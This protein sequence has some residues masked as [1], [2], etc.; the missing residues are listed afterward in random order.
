MLSGIGEPST[1]AHRGSR[2]RLCPPLQRCTSFRL[3]R[4]QLQGS[5][6]APPSWPHNDLSTDC[7]SLKLG[8]PPWKAVWTEMTPAVL[9]HESGQLVYDTGTRNHARGRWREWNHQGETVCLA[10]F[11]L[12]LGRRSSS[13][14][15]PVKVTVIGGRS[16]PT[17][18]FL[19]YPNPIL[20]G[21]YQL[22]CQAP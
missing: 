20:I 8:C 14:P 9:R 12:L 17:P 15:L 3:S 2:D 22:R 10:N 4:T 11:F 1:S 19:G 16:C 7:E 13:K 6:R 5:P 21:H 18:A